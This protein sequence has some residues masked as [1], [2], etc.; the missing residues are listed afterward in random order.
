MRRIVIAIDGYAATGKSTT[1]RGVAD[2]LGYLYIDSG[3]M[4]R[5]AAWYLWQKGIRCLEQMEEKTLIGLFQDFSLEMRQEGR[6]VKLSLQG[7]PLGEELR[8][9]EIGQLASL[10][11]TVAWLRER[12]VA[13]QR[14]LGEKGGIVMDG[15]D[16]GTVVFPEAPLKVF[17]KA[18][19][20]TR[21]ERRYQELA[22]QGLQVSRSHIQAELLERDYRDE[23][24]PLSPLRPAPD[25]RLLDTTSL[26]IPEQIAIVLRWAEEL[27]Y[28]PLTS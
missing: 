20:E 24:R 1:A 25:A 2:V 7:R 11:G 17:M 14:R 26:T 18:A 9:P 12:L 21:V 23:H 19:L 5:A 8:R 3:A 28:A 13:E 27:I 10:V 15:R 16:I 6:G 4:Y 22:A